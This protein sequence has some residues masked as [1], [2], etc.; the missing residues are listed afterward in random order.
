MELTSDLDFQALKKLVLEFEVGV[1]KM[2]NFFCSYLID[3]LKEDSNKISKQLF[4][5]LQIHLLGEK[6]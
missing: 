4:E 2:K 5:L 3:L 1:K 6:K